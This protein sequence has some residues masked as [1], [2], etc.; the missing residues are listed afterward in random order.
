MFAMLQIPAQVEGRVD[1][2]RKHMRFF[3][4]SAAFRE[5]I[6]SHRDGASKIEWR[7]G[8]AVKIGRL[9]AGDD[10]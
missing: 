4:D 6:R 7:L 2:V 8:E 5:N 1:A 3:F 9:L 10:M